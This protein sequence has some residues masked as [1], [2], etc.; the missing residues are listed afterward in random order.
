MKRI[1]PLV[2]VIIPA[3]NAAKYIKQTIDSVLSQK[4]TN[5]EIIVI[6]DGS[7]DQTSQIIA[8]YDHDIIYVFQENRG[9]GAARNAGLQLARGDLI[10]FLDADDLWCPDALLL[11]VQMLAKRPNIDVVYCWWEYVDEHGRELPEKGRYSQRG[12]LLDSLL[13]SNRFPIMTSLTR[14]TCIDKINGFDE[15]RCITEDWDFWLRLAKNGCQFEYLPH[16]LAK[17]RFHGNNW[18][19]D[20]RNRQRDYIGVLDK[21]FGTGDYPKRVQVIRSKAYG[22]VYLTSAL[23]YFSQ[24]KLPEGK[25]ELLKAVDIWPEIICQEETYYRL[26]CAE[27]PPGYRDT[28]QFRDLPKMERLIKDWLDELLRDKSLVA[29]VAKYS[30]TASAKQALALARLYYQPGDGIQARRL[31]YEA[32]SSSPLAVMNQQ[33]IALWFKTFLGKKLVEKLK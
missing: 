3:Y 26:A 29:K 1:K 24:D 16:V 21:F 10:S 7:T 4:L 8:S 17:Y 32:L 5:Y 27:Q 13:L 9:Q 22:Q 11:L 31:L 2:S 30:K 23:Y 25:E 6:D 12:N 33:S 15:S 20:V 28:N 18:T 14:R 19:L